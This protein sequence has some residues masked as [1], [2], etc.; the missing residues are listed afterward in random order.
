MFNKLFETLDLNKDELLSRTELHT[1]AKRLEWQWPEAPIFALLDLLTVIGPISK[2]TFVNY[3][4]QVSED[5]LG[6]YGKILLK[7]PYFSIPST[8]KNETYQK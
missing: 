6:P 5:P 7:A 1:A 2:S 8:T 3:M 4:Q